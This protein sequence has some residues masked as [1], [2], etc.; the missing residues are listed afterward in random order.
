MASNP[1]PA[2]RL[3]R[4]LR[5]TLLLVWQ[6]KYHGADGNL[7]ASLCI[8][9]HWMC[10][11]RYALGGDMQSRLYNSSFVHRK[12]AVAPPLGQTTYVG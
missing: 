1:H 11:L 7:C 4:A 5:K 3:G 2:P 6:A 10:P 8:T 12:A 9:A